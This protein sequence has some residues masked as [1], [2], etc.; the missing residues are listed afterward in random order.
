MTIDTAMILAAGFGTRMGALTQDLPKPLL[1]V[2]G[3]PL[4][5]HSLDIA[6][7]VGVRRA[8]INLHYRGDLIRAHLT[9]RTAPSVAFSEEKPYI[10]DTGG[11]LI[12]ALPLLGRN[13][14]AVL[15][16]DAVFPGVNPLRVLAAEW[17]AERMDAL[18]LLVPA[19]RARAYTREG[20]FFLPAEGAAPARRG[21]ALR[22]PF[23]FTGAQIIAP[24]ALDGAP[25]GAFS[26]NLVWD[27]LLAAGRLR[28]VTYPGE[29]VDVG[30]PEGLQEAERTLAA[31]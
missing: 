22:A 29:W 21:H 10:L 7:A 16:S 6:A 19:A 20:D 30:T 28:A 15:N 4:I 14:F 12:H 8:V 27:S 17:D 18:M 25:T 5:D 26:L 9:G 11:G 13:P 2:G 31:A 3:R 23:V 24:I 1:Q